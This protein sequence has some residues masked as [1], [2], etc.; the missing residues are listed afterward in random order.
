MPPNAP[1]T[2][3]Y[4]TQVMNPLLGPSVSGVV[5]CSTVMSLDGIVIGWGG[6]PH[7]SCTMF[8]DCSLW[9]NCWY[10]RYNRGCCCRACPYHLAGL[11]TKR[12]LQARHQRNDPRLER[13]GAEVL[14]RGQVIVESCRITVEVGN[15]KHRR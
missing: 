15:G 4:C 13:S 5:N 3:G 12:Y 8:M 7:T 14:D 1:S 6:S 9:F 2:P 10:D 11:G